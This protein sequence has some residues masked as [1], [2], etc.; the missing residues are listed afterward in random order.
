[1]ATQLRRPRIPVLFAAFLPSGRC[2]HD[3]RLCGKFAVTTSD[4]DYASGSGT[5]LFSLKTPMCSTRIAVSLP[6]RPGA[7]VLI[8]LQRG[9]HTGAATPPKRCA[10]ILRACASLSPVLSSCSRLQA[11]HKLVVRPSAKST[12]SA[13]N[14]TTSYDR[15]SERRDGSPSLPVVQAEN[16]TSQFPA[17]ASLCPGRNRLHTK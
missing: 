16:R 13:P 8:S 4:V 10:P 17:A 6:P 5:R 7:L 14:N 9:D 15:Q 1:M 12:T 2:Y 3:P 11:G